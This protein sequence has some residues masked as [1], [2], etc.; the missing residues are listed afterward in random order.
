MGA[1]L[2]APALLTTGC[3]EEVF[4]TNGVVQEQLASNAK[5]TEATVWGMASHMNQ[6]PTITEDA[7]Y[8]WGYPRSCT[9]AT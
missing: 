9:P 2:V 6:V 1:A 7:A 8:D 5:A 3:I 4:P